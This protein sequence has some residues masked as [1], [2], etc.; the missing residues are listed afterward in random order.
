[1][2]LRHLE[3]FVAV[4]DAASFSRAADRLHVVQ[5]AVSAGIRTLEADL[6][7]ELFTRT[8]RGATLTGAGAALL[9][10][11]RATLAAAAAARDA[12]DEVR[13]GLRGTVRLG[14][15]QSMRPPAPNPA[16]LLASFAETHPLV[17][18]VVGHGGGSLAMVQQVRDGRLDLAFVSAQT[19]QPGVELT[20]LSS[21]AVSV[22]CPARHRFASRRSL[23]LAEVAPEPCAELP[24]LWGTRTENDRAFAAAGLTRQIAYE[25]NDTSTLV[26]F[27]RAGLAISLLPMSLVADPRELVS[28][29]LRGAA[30]TFQVSIAAP[31]ERRLAASAR[32]LHDHIRNGASAVA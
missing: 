17:D 24:L 2:N 31:G 9:P 7:A 12:V 14:I 25:I 10:E 28:I 27:V 19:P 4:A 8:A 22:V 3:T 21:Q 11:A 32:A 18:V 5:S 16:Q 20:P 23:T 29:P 15:M 13:G 6:G 26:E 1:M 30:P